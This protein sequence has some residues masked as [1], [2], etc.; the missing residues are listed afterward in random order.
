[1]TSYGPGGDAAT[2]QLWQDFTVDSQT[3]ELRFFIHGGDAAV[4]LLVNGDEVRASR[5]RRDNAVETEVRWRLE[6]FR[7]Q[8]VRL[9]IDDDLTAPW[10]FVGARAF[11]L[12]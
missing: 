5:G 2:G 1:V 9:L 10:G 6:P 12:R 3:S 4:K 7:G 11:E 8:T